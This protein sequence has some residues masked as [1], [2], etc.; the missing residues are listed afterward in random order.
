M[1]TPVETGAGEP[2]GEP[3]PGPSS[4]PYAVF[5]KADI[6]RARVPH[7]VIERLPGTTNHI[8]LTVDD[9]NNS[10]VVKHYGEFARD[11]GMRLTF[12]LNGLRPSWTDNAE[13]LRPMVESG[14]IQ[15]GNHTWSHPDLTKLKDAEIVDELSRNDKFIRNTYGAQAKPFYRPPF[16][17]YNDRV[18]NVAA[19]LGYSTAVMWFGTLLD[20]VFIPKPT[21][22]K[23]AKQYLEPGR[24]VI[25]HANATTVTSQ[26]GFIDKL[27]HERNLVPVTLNDIWSH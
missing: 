10:R 25:G 21:L 9:G 6:T 18:V 11:T 1:P 14:Q 5:T 27:L 26:F 7:G 20:A 3:T 23:F 16:G 8:A 19:D 17:Y 15:L 12:F 13:L 22:R 4:Y 2:G 24:I